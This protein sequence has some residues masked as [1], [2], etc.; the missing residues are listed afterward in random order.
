YVEQFRENSLLNAEQKPELIVDWPKALEK[1]LLPG[2]L[3]Q[4]VYLRRQANLWFGADLALDVDDHDS[5]EYKAACVALGEYLHQHT[6]FLSLLRAS[7]QIVDLRQLAEQWQQDFNL[8][9]TD[10]ALALLD[11]LTALVS[12]ARIWADD[13]QQKVRPFLQV[14]VQLWLRELRRMLVSVSPE[15]RLVHSDDLIDSTSPLHLPIL[16]C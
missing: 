10:Y 16:H 1:E 4:G 6:A 13:S 12:T 9:S 7:N 14:R 3:T 8:S 15:P 2:A 5:H 11:S